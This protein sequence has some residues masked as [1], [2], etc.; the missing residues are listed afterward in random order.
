MVSVKKAEKITL[1]LPSEL[2]ERLS[3]LK[4]ELHLSVSAIYKEALMQYIAKKEAE[5]WEKAAQ[6]ASNEYKNN[7][8]LREWN[9]FT[10]DTHEL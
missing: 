6:L 5:L 4:D 10:G 2:K 7:P 8:E 1:T 3:I 9:E